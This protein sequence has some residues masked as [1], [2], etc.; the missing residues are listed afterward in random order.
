MPGVVGVVTVPEGETVLDPVPELDPEPLVPVLLE[1]LVPVLEPLPPELEDDPAAFSAWNSAASSLPSP[2]LS[3]AL[4]SDASDGVALTSSICRKPSPSRSSDLNSAEKSAGIP[5]VVAEVPLL[6]LLEPAVPEPELLDAGDSAGV[7]VVGDVGEVG[8]VTV[9]ACAAIL[10][11][12][13]MATEA[14]L[15]R[16]VMLFPFMFR[17]ETLEQKACLNRAFRS[18]EEDPERRRRDRLDEVVVEAGIG[19]LAPVF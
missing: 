4:N 9:W 1:P 7:G 14:A 17:Q 10:N 6:E 18:R 19:G 16:S 15:L 13:R 3:A 5:D 12:A 11:A 8:E 2:F